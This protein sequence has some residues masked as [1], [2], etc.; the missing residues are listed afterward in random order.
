MPKLKTGGWVTIL[1]LS[2]LSTDIQKIKLNQW[3]KKNCHCNLLIITKTLIS[4][5]KQ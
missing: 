2:C 1:N 5:Q 4:L 3:I